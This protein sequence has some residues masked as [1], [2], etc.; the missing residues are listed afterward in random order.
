MGLACEDVE[1]VQGAEGVEGLESREEDYGVVDWFLF[2][3][4]HGWVYV[5]VVL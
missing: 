4:C 5:C 2:W 1:R 3:G